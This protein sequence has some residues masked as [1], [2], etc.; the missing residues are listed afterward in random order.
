MV[1]RCVWSRNLKNEEAMTCVGPQLHR[2]ARER[3]REGRERERDRGREREREKDRERGRE[4]ERERKTVREREREGENVLA[5]PRCELY[6][7]CLYRR[8]VT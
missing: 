3:G 2:I 5:F 8:C 1:R 4:G 6:L 7:V